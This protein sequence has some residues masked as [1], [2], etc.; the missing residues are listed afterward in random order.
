MYP[1]PSPDDVLEVYIS[2]LALLVCWLGLPLHVHL[3]FRLATPTRHTFIWFLWEI[4]RLSSQLTVPTLF[5]IVEKICALFS[6]C[7]K[8][9]IFMPNI[10]P[11]SR[12]N[13]QTDCPTNC[14]MWLHRTTKNMT[15]WHIRSVSHHHHHRLQLMKNLVILHC[16]TNTPKAVEILKAQWT[17]QCTSFSSSEPSDLYN[18][19]SFS[20]LFH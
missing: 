5:F 19:Y 13:I 1:S 12:K 14:G 18:I 15:T 10:N 17:Q 3:W 7:C 8:R 2:H 16:H 20:M 4:D 11:W 9:K 6:Q